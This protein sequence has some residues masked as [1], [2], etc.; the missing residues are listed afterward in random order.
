M[1]WPSHTNMQGIATQLFL[2]D[3]PHPS[4]PFSSLTEE[5]LYL[6]QF[7]GLLNC[8]YASAPDSCLAQ[9]EMWWMG[10]RARGTYGNDR[11]WK[12]R[13]IRW[14]FVSLNPWP[15]KAIS[16]P[17][18]ISARNWTISAV[19]FPMN[20]SVCP[21]FLHLN[22]SKLVEEMYRFFLEVSN[23]DKNNQRLSS[24]GCIYHVISDI[25][26]VSTSSVRSQRQAGWYC[27]DSS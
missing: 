13:Q 16:F 3:T 24:L 5:L 10:R 27:G 6:V 7:D 14:A 15:H 8:E 19:F 26:S 4:T 9:S 17:F 11:A 2:F 20:I 21:N 1:R 25:Y 23:I 22:Q 12:E 18:P